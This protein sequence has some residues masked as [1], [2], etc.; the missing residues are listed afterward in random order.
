MIGY[1]DRN[2][3]KSAICPKNVARMKESRQGRSGKC[4][5]PVI[6]I[7]LRR[8]TEMPGAL[9]GHAQAHWCIK[10]QVSSQKISQSHRDCQIPSHAC[11]R[12]PCRQACIDASHEKKLIR[13][14]PRST[15]CSSHR[16]SLCLLL[17][18]AIVMSFRV[19]GH[20]VLRILLP[21]ATYLLSVH[22][23]CVTIRHVKLHTH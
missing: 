19:F 1:G 2:G 23:E 21:S 15:Q 17:R 16:F 10:S 11:S 5:S 8:G 7:P 4:I 9:Y 22:L 6:E 20:L 12:S 13:G 14:S 18:V 3:S